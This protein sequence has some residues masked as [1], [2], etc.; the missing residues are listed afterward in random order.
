[1]PSDFIAP[2]EVLPSFTDVIANSGLNPNIPIIA[3][4]IGTEQIR[5]T[6]SALQPSAA[7]ENQSRWLNVG[8][9]ITIPPNTKVWMACVNS[10]F[11][12][13][14]YAD[15]WSLEAALR[16]YPELTQPKLQTAAITNAESFTLLGI[17]YR[18]AFTFTAVPAGGVRWIKFVP[19]ADRE[20]AII[21]RTLSPNVAGATYHLY[22]GCSGWSPTAALTA[23]N[24]S[25]R[26]PQQTAL[27]TIQYNSAPPT[28]LLGLDK[29]III[30]SG[31]G[32]VAGESG[33]PAGT[34]SPEQ[35]FTIYQA[36]GIGFFAEIKNTSTGTQD[37]DLTLLFA[38][39]PPTIAA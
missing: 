28:T 4:N 30:R 11:V 3:F 1:M 31:A 36:G 10:S 20:V 8:D 39:I 27:S 19:P 5:Y 7:A 9:S 15:N 37:I 34:L 21:S 18:M 29:N 12:N 25:D 33:R 32:T 35:G 38:E 16:V 26:A 14:Q 6:V 17:V 2:V 24:Q 22:T 13:L 23:Y